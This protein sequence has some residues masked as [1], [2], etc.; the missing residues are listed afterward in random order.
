MK[1]KLLLMFVTI[2]SLSAMSGWSNGQE[3]NQERLAERWR[4]TARSDE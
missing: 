4:A 3:D 1:E 2:L